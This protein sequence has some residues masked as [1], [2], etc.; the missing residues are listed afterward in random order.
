MTD[1]RRRC[2]DVFYV[3]TYTDADGVHR[4]VGKGKNQR[5]WTHYKQAQC[6][7]ANGADPQDAASVIVCGIAADL[8]ER[9]DY[10]IAIVA[11][12]LSEREAYRL[13]MELIRKYGIWQPD[14]KG[15]L[16]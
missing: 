5:A 2:T 15:T 9:R 13:E 8:Y 4:Y 7:V 3:Y 6:I 14:G 11:D 10:S 1:Q 12:N 16:F